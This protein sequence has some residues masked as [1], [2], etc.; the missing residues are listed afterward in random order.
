MKDLTEVETGFGPLA[1]PVTI[2][3]N[4]GATTR[5]DV[6]AQVGGNEGDCKVKK[7]G[8]RLRCKSK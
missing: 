5:V 2:T 3:L 7:A 1:G 6:V 8:T 4:H